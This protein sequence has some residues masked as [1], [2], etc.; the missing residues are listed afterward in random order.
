MWI[1]FIKCI[2]IYIRFQDNIKINCGRYLK[3][4]QKT[5][6]KMYTYLNFEAVFGWLVEKLAI[7]FLFKN[8]YFFVL[9]I[10]FLIFYFK[11]FFY[12]FISF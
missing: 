7:S 11:L 1:C 5:G 12:V 10:F 4:H 3:S 9:K 8:G 6:K 2:L